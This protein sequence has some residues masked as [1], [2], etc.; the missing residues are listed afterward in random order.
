M[1]PFKMEVLLPWKHTEVS[2]NTLLPAR[3]AV[4]GGRADRR[5]SPSFDQSVESVGAAAGKGRW[6]FSFQCCSKHTRGPLSCD[7]IVLLF[8]G[9]LRRS[10]VCQLPGHLPGV[11]VSAGSRQTGGAGVHQQS[12]EWRQT[13]GGPKHRGEE[14]FCLCAEKH[15]LLG[16]DPHFPVSRWPGLWG[17]WMR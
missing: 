11:R 17:S 7:I 14:S 4:R 16:S 10:H 2:L 6:A 5:G 12:S 8:S 1:D 3:G 9:G 15:S 13:C